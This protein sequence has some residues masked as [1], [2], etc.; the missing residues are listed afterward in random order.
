MLVGS[1]ESSS[2]G[3]LQ[4]FLEPIR[5]VDGVMACVTVKS[6]RMVKENRTAVQMFRDIVKLLSLLMSD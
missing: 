5:L 2:T 1:L 6:T 3:N 4:F